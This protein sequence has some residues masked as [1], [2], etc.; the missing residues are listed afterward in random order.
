MKSY[1]MR[2]S[3]L[4]LLAFLL[5]AVL[6]FS[7][8]RRDRTG[9]IQLITPASQSTVEPRDVAFSWQTKDDGPVRFVL[10]TQSFQTIVL[11]TTLTGDALT[12]P[13]TLHADATYMWRIEQG[14]YVN[15]SSFKIVD[16]A[17]RFVGHYSG[18]AT[19]TRWLMGSGSSTSTHQAEIDL[20]RDGTGMAV[21]GDKEFSVPLYQY[22]DST[23]VFAH[24]FVHDGRYLT[25][26]FVHD[27]IQI[28]TSVGGLGGN[29][30]YSLSSG[31]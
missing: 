4:T 6:V 17:A 20:V 9:G 26:D 5:S 15:S 28:L 31:N 23:I 29:T 13:Y 14:D 1:N 21:S 18:I 2:N 10:G 30:T 3:N 19:V 8:C 27:S 25:L 24:P 11:D 7:A 12:Y 16:V 22:T